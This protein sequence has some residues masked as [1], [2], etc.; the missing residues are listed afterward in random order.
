MSHSMSVLKC[1]YEKSRTKRLHEMP[2]GECVCAL[3]IKCLLSVLKC[4]YEMSR[5]KCLYELP[6]YRPYSASV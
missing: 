6:L 2:E 4:W 5:T 1:W 3:R